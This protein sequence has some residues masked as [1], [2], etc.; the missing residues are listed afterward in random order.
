MALTAA[1]VAALNKLSEYLGETQQGNT[2]VGTFI[3]QVNSRALS[4]S[5]LISTLF[6]S[7]KS[8]GWDGY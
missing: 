6:S 1:Q 4:N 5:T 3:S 7:A 8:T 2:G